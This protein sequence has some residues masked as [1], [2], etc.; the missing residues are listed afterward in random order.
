MRVER[1]AIRRVRG[2]GDDKPERGRRGTE[3]TWGGAA[4][5][6]NVFSHGRTSGSAETPAH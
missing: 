6:R 1:K 2:A 3:M 4:A 5:M